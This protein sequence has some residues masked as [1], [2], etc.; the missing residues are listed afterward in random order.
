M[1]KAFITGIAGQDGSYLTEYLSKKNYKIYGI[2]RRNSI[3]EHQKNRLENL[4]NI[5]NID[6]VYGD[7]EDRSSLDNLLKKIKPDEIYNLAAQSHVRIS[8]DVPEYTIKT[9]ALGVFNI[10][11]SM[12]ANSHK[13]KFYQ[14]S[15]SEMFGRSVDKDGFQRETTKFEPVSPYGCAKVFGFN[16]VKHYRKAYKLFCSNGI[17]FNH[18]SPRR[19]SNFVTSK[20]IK[21][22]VEIKLGLKNRLY[23]GNLDSYRDWGHSKDYVRAMHL[24]LNHKIPDDFVIATGFSKSIRELCKIVFGRL[25]LDYKK[26]VRQNKKFLR[27]E[28]LKYLRGDSKKARKILKWKPQITFEQMIAETTEFWLD[29]YNGKK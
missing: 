2:L 15:S 12:K 14:A 19:G 9:N 29:Y 25:D 20:V 22:A 7:V 11:E 13:S 6:L 23:L 16:L 10:L 17:L 4:D 26:Y 3:T 1:K 21:T 5:N 28:E 18:E 8:F 27:P 24:I